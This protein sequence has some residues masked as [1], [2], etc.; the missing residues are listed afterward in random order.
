MGKT[1][2][3]GALGEELVA[4]FLMKRGFTVT[5]RNFRKKWGELDVIA[6]KKNILHFVEVKSVSRSIFNFPKYT[7]SISRTGRVIHETPDDRSD[8]LLYRVRKDTYRPKTNSDEFVW[9]N[10]PKDCFRPEDNI[11]P[12]KVARLKRAIQSYL[13]SGRVSSETKWQFDAA[14]VYIDREHKKAR[15]DFIKDIIL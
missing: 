9:S 15:I 13:L 6:V 7:S 8:S 4:R 14:A 2:K 3:V 12:M 1:Q 11:H 10:N 5:D